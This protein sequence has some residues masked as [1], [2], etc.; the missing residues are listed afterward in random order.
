L[1]LFQNNFI[2]HVTKCN[3]KSGDMATGERND[4]TS[5]NKDIGYCLPRLLCACEL[6]PMKTVNMHELDVICN[7]GFRHIFN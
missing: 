4:G 7:S 6:W 1:K 5:A 3:I 2:S